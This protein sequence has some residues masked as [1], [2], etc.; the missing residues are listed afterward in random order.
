MNGKHLSPEDALDVLASYAIANE[1]TNTLYLG[2]TEVL[3]QR[4]AIENPY[5][6]T[7]I[8][9]LLNYFPHSIF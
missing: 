6:L 1:G 2:L 9:I 7:E 3:C 5:S 8:E 4:D